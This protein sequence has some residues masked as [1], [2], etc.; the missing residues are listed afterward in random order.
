MTTSVTTNTSSSSSYS[1]SATTSSSRKRLQAPTPSWLVALLLALVLGAL[2]RYFVLFGPAYPTTC[3]ILGVGCPKPVRITGYAHPDYEPLRETFTTGW[4]DGDEIGASFAA[5]VDG[6]QVVDLYGGFSDSA[7]RYPYN[8]STLQLVFSSTKAVTSI[9]LLHMVEQN[10]IDL[11]KPVAAYWPEFGEGGKERVTVGDLLQHRGG[12]PFL[13]E[14]R[15]PTPEDVA[16]EEPL[17][18]KIAGQPHAFGGVSRSAYHAT[19]RGWFLNEVVKRAHPEGKS[20]R[21]IMQD[22]IVPKLYPSADETTTTTA[23]P[24]TTSTYSFFYGLSPAN[25]HLHRWRVSPLQTLP[26]PDI[27]FLI[28]VP[29]PILRWLGKV[30]LPP[31]IYNSYV[32]PR[33]V[34]AK[35]LLNSGPKFAN[36]RA[37]PDNYNAEAVLRGVGGSYGG[38]TNARTL[39]RLAA[40]MLNNGTLDGSTLLRA[41]TVA[42][43]SRVLD[44]EVDAVIGF[45]MQWTSGGWGYFEMIPAVPGR[46]WIGWFGAGGSV[47]MWNRDLNMAVGYVPNFCQFESTGDRRTHR[48]IR[49]LVE[50]AEKVRARKKAGAAV[51]GD[52]A[53]SSQGSR[54]EL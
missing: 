54:A 37:W 4:I 16:D 26:F 44:P 5:Y 35:A 21:E 2:Y 46:G 25:Y 22:D 12:V 10:Y 32:D 36:P 31:V 39:A 40:F 28:L 9:V 45:P 20:L 41:E 18:I 53:A 24:S 42:S 14:D 15:V 50:I 30:P 19:T 8:E 27:L 47:I 52:A 11:A 17:A 33:S 49:Q 3:R 6:E 1:S 23:D 13:D 48:M 51:G 7:R 38:L 29:D 34:S 43:G